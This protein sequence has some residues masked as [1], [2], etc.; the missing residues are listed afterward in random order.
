[1]RFGLPS[2][3]NIEVELHDR[4]SFYAEFNDA[5]PSYRD[6]LLKFNKHTDTTRHEPKNLSFNIYKKSLNRY[7]D[8]VYKSN[9][10]IDEQKKEVL[11]VSH[12][13]MKSVV[14]INLETIS[15]ELERR[16]KIQADEVDHIIKEDAKRKKIEEETKRKLEE[17][18]QRKIL[19][20]QKKKEEEA[21]KIRELE[22]IER[23]KKEAE[24]KKLEEDRKKKEEEEKR[25][26]EEKAL[27]EKLKDENERQEKLKEDQIAS[28]IN[29][30]NEEFLKY[31]SEIKDIKE[32]IVL[33]LNENKELKKSVNQLKR[34]I[35]PKFGQLSN[36][37]LQLVKINNE[38]IELITMSRNAD[39]LAYKWILN[40]VAK[41]IVDQAETE[42][43]VQ[44]AAALP[45]SKLACSL[46]HSFPEFEYFLTARFVKK[47]PF[48]IG[49]TCSIDSEEGRARMGWKRKD[50]KWEDDVKYDERVSGI[51]T[52]WAAM[53]KETDYPQL[54]KY[55]FEASWIFLARMLNIEKDL[56]SNTHFSIVSNWW[57]ACAK[58]FLPKYGRQA[59]K[60]LKTV[61][62]DW[63]NSVA[64]KKFPAAARLLIL[65]ED[66]LQNNR[67][68]SIKE[69]ENI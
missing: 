48:I 40:F 33:K 7:V 16:L 59:V 31:K 14:S 68:D 1:M 6:S 42:V 29:K 21:K 30:I 53:T 69:M 39:P 28:N 23:K 61:S 26:K 47:C 27:K 36:S 34:K 25:E 51:C 37:I 54:A 20:E 32:N 24:L 41:A 56:L 19:E 45:L 12:E 17:E 50:N 22:E 9:L 18:R 2:D 49:Y 38:V 57:E 60:L 67:I 65:G 13:K 15:K 52:V 66:W 11:T 4:P 46:L 64:D 58:Y 55:S 10:E 5:N 35:N 43:I 63:T 3:Y 62:I 8:N 44:P